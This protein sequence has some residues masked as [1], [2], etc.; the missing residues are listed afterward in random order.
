MK[1]SMLNQRNPKFIKKKTLVTSKRPSIEIKTD[2]GND[3]EAIH[4]SCF[5]EQFT[6]LY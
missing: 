3:I 6:T 5:N 4:N 1:Q 2:H